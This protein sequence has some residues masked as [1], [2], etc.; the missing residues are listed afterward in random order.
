VPTA[1]A[2]LSRLC[3]SLA[4]TSKRLEKR[5]ILAEFLR[6][7]D[8]EEV[9]PAVLLLT[10]KILPESEQKALNVGWAT[11]SKA[12]EGPRQVTLQ[13][14]PLTILAVKETFGKVAATTGKDSVARKRR[15]LETLMGR[16]TEADRRWLL[17]S[18]FVDMRIGVSEGV[19]LEAIADAASVPAD[20]V[21]TANQLAGD[22]GHVAATALSGGGPALAGMSL[23]MFTPIKPMMAELGEDAESI[24][25]EHGGRTAVEYKFDGARIQIHRRGGEVRIFSRRL[26]DVTAGL[27]E[28]VEIARSLPAKEFVL[29]G[30]VVAVDTAGKPLPFQDLMRRFRRVHDVETLRREMPLELHLFDILYRDGRVLLALS[31]EERWRELA[32]LSPPKSLAERKVVTTAVEIEAFFREALQHGHEGLMAKALDSDYAVG[33]R[34]KKWFKLKPVETLDCVITAAEWGHGRR[35]GTLS[36]YHLAVRDGDSWQMIGKTFKGL[37]DAERAAMTDRLRSLAV[38]EHEWWVEVR[39][40]IVVEVSYDEVQKSPTYPSGFALRFARISRIREDMGPSQAGAFEHLKMLYHRKF[41]R[42]GQV[43]V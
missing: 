35:K 21:R 33:K 39:P 41:E 19:M 25:K 27:P 29:E 36:N 28:I 15:L 9:A 3:E 22:L 17:G 18:L 2:A 40:E 13:D 14:E 26:T 24:L 32:S 4:A 16:A 38:K 30:E 1:F 5:R 20:L 12:L 43:A 8:P 23:Q 34:G 10:A 6:S 11:L 37:T 42:K 7:L 31:Y